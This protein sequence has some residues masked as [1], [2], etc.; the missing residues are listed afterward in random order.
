MKPIEL[1]GVVA[2]AIFVAAQLPMLVKALRV[3]SVKSYSGLHLA[4]G[5]TGNAIWWVHLLA[6]VP[7]LT[8]CVLHTYYI[9]TMVAMSLLWL[10]WRGGG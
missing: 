1:A 7:D 10:R 2:S 9:V 3:R 8:V 6:N 5:T 4:L